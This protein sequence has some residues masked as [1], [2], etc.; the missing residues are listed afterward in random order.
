MNK[1]ATTFDID[2]S[3]GIGASEAAA[4]LGLDRFASPA[5]IWAR[6]VNA[7]PEPEE[8]M[9]MRL[10]K[11]LEPIVAE[12]YSERTGLKVRKRSRAYYD[13]QHPYLYAHVDRLADGRVVE[14][15]TTS[16]LGEEWGPDGS[17]DIPVHV[18]VQALLQMRYTRRPRA[19]VA[20]LLWGRDLRLYQL[21]Y[22]AALADDIVDRLAGFWIDYVATG[23]MPPVDGSDAT[24]AFLR[25]RFPMDDG[26]TLALEP[27]QL[28]LVTRLMAA[29]ADEERARLEKQAAENELK[30]LMGE[31][32]TLSYPTGQITW[33]SY[34]VKTTA[35]QYIAELLASQ[36]GIDPD[37]W[38]EL[39][40]AN[41]TEETRRTFRVKEK[42]L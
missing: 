21:E 14:I 1:T 34:T 41:T 29:R 18:M 39:V 3:T 37:A 38:S 12:L 8:R 4:V 22:D 6:K 33:R 32:S 20:A 25:R 40:Q 30:A 17:S 42:E 2:R 9:P 16:R 36:A 10:G 15:K 26:T 23:T 11:M 24:T 27:A 13:P 7:A 31:A 19:D 35:W 5:D 28:P